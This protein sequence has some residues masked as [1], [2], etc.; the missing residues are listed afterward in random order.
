MTENI[1]IMNYVKATMP[2][3]DTSHKSRAQVLHDFQGRVRN[4]AMYGTVGADEEDGEDMNAVIEAKLKK[5]KNLTA[6]EKAYLMRTNPIM[7]AQYRRIQVEKNSVEVRI[8]M[9]KSKEQVTAIQDSAISGISKD[10]PMREYIVAAINEVV[11]KFRETDEYKKL[12]EKLPNARDCSNVPADNNESKADKADETGAI[13]ESDGELSDAEDYTNISYSFSE[14]G[15][16][17]AT[18]VTAH[19]SSAFRAGA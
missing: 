12:P 19:T 5:G 4:Y 2:A 15:Y 18:A 16:Q 9:A 7:Y 6:E 13:E 10:D 3:E 1:N 11:R 8:K 14:S 17:E